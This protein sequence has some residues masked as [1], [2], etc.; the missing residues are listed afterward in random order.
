MLNMR[1]RPMQSFLTILQVALAVACMVSV[2]SYKTNVAAAIDRFESSTED[3]VIVMGGTETRSQ[4]GYMRTT[5]NIFDD[6]D[7]SELAADTPLVEA[8]TP[9]I[10]SWGVKAEVDGTLYQLS[11]GAAVGPGHRL[12]AD[13]RMIEGDFITTADMEAGARVVVISDGL[14]K[15]LFG[16]RPYVGRTLGLIPAQLRLESAG[17]LNAAAPASP[18]EY[19]VIGVYDDRPGYLESRWRRVAPI[20]WPVAADPGRTSPIGGYPYGTLVIKAAPGKAAAVRDR[21]TSMVSG[22][23]APDSSGGE[24][25]MIRSAI[26]GGSYVAVSSGSDGDSDTDVKSSASVVFESSRDIEQMV[27]SSMTMT[28]LLLGGATLVAVIVSA[29]GIQSVMLVNIAERTREIG[30]RRVL[31]ASRR[32]IVFQFTLDSAT[33][34]AVG[35]VVGGLLAF[36]LYPYLMRSVF[37][38][39]GP[40]ELLNVSAGPSA[41]AI[42]AGIA[43]S[44][45][46]GA[47]L[48]K[49]DAS[50]HGHAHIRP[51]CLDRRGRLGCPVSHAAGKAVYAFQLHIRRGASG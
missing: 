26:A 47:D 29:L 15:I 16:D 49:P 8:V 43:V 30:L 19:R 6:N 45:V 23:P 32:S 25:V 28:T 1:R 18:V 3:I 24:G 5:Y 34:A 38:K 33:L 46:A 11:N 20:M 12:V 51:G 44:A 2:A 40:G 41:W 9:F 4:N 22:R 7:I 27:S 10:D 31:G 17:D 48:I 50:R 42:C 21:I 37:S 14:G 39:V 13:L 36:A 35:G